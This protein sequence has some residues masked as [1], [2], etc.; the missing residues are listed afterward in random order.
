[1][2]FKNDNDDLRSLV[3]PCATKGGTELLVQSRA[4]G[5]A[6]LYIEGSV[7]LSK[8]KALKLAWAIIDE[9]APDTY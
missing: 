2:K 1:M 3:L 7:F 4:D 9:L 5:K 6:G 8:A